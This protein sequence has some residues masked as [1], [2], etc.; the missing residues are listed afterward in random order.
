LDPAVRDKRERA[1]FGRARV[2]A[3]GEAEYH[4]AFTFDDGPKYTTT[5]QI[6]DILDRYDIPASFF[7]VGW[8]FGGTSEHARR[9]AEV[10]ADIVRR[11]YHVGN[12]TY[13]HKRL[14]ALDLEAMS[15]EIDRN[16][17]ALT[18]TLGYTPRAFRPP[19]GAVNKA[20]RAHLRSRGLT[21][22]RWAIDTHDFRGGRASALRARTL[23]AIIKRRGGVVLMHD[24]KE[25]TARALGGIL[26]D[27]ERENCRRLDHGERV[28]APVSIHYF[29]RNRDGSPRPV[30][31]EV[32][33]RTQTYLTGLPQRCRARDQAAAQ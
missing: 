20:V 19:Y 15:R 16:T 21:E 3:G 28:I 22:I 30:P 2:V 10:L 9:N 5:P 26:H 14:P 33:A 29:V 31:P 7:V 32:A 13:H 12:H 4:V 6:L 27:L 18:Q 8:R 24:T 23:S 1:E 17:R 25:V 11:G